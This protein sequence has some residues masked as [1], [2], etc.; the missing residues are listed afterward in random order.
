VAHDVVAFTCALF[1]AFAVEKHDAAALV[2]D[3][4]P[5]LHGV[6]HQR[7]RRAPDTQHLRQYLLRQRQFAGAGTI[8]ALQQPAA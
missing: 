8:G 5:D 3:Q 6:R 7:Y 4:A 2:L 1:E